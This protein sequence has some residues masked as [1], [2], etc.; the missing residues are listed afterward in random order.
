MSKLPKQTVQAL[1]LQLGKFTLAGI[2]GFTKETFKTQ[3]ENAGLKLYESDLPGFFEK[4]PEDVDKDAFA[5]LLDYAGVIIPGQRPAFGG[6]TAGTGVR[7]NSRERAEQVVTSTEPNAVETFMELMTEM[8][9]L[10]KEADALIKGKG[11]I[12]IAIK[13]VGESIKH[14]KKVEEVEE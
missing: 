9:Q 13:N 3:V 10:A 14:R 7:I 5:D 1:L 11:Q 8:L 6:R 12:S 4:L 2:P